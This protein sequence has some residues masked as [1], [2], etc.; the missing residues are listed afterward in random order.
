MLKRTSAWPENRKCS[1]EQAGF[2]FL[3]AITV[4]IIIAILA[5]VAIP[6]YNG[7]V[8]NQ[9][10]LVVT[11]IARSASVTLS[12]YFRRNGPPPETDAGLKALI[13]IPDP[14][15]Y[16]ILVGPTGNATWVKVRE[17]ANHSITS[18]EVPFRQ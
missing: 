5:A 18:P 7:Y 11:N 16:E 2:T 17:S 3:E 15:Q 13:S 14:S 8:T 9:K 1:Q 12:S 10:Q 6:T 4:S